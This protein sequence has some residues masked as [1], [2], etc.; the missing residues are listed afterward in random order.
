MDDK[1]AGF[2][3]RVRKQYKGFDPQS[4]PESYRTLST[5]ENILFEYV[6][7]FR[8]QFQQ[9]YPLRPDPLLFPQNECSTQVLHTVL[10]A[11]DTFHRNLFAPQSVRPNCPSNNCTIMR[12][13]QNLFRT[14]FNMSLYKTLQS[15]YRTR[16]HTRSVLCAHLCLLA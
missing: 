10:N 3:E 12:V 6:D 8:K 16:I 14:T 9:L 4:A 5:D 7:N 15:W 11:F 2:A 1:P 13:V